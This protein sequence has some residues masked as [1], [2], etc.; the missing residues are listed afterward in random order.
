MLYY[1]FI[2]VLGTM[3]LLGGFYRL[4]NYFSVSV[5]VIKAEPKPKTASTPIASKPIVKLPKVAAQKGISENELKAQ[6]QGKGLSSSQ[7]KYLHQ[8]FLRGDSAQ[9]IA[10]NRLFAPYLG[11][12]GFDS[13]LNDLTINDFFKLLVQKYPQKQ[14]AAMPSGYLTEPKFNSF[15]TQIKKGERRN[16]S[17]QLKNARIVMCPIEKN[18][19]WYLLI[20]EKHNNKS[21]TLRCLD[22]FNSKA[23]HSTFFAQGKK[24][25]RALF[26][27][28]KDLTFN[29]RSIAIPSQKDGYNCGTV[30]SFYGEQF[31]QGKS[32]AQYSTLAKKSFDY[33]PYRL[34][35]GQKLAQ[36]VTKS[37]IF[38]QFDLKKISS[39]KAKVENVDKSLPAKRIV[40]NCC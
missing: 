13:W 34:Q 15:I 3:A 17:T 24:L 23:Q 2:I 20:I 25:I 28:N 12:K 37:P 30:I 14:I 26:K 31:C 32:L 16:F 33:T 21:F 36:D 10:G 22:G 11:K 27:I 18:A 29:E 35:M 39:H 6:I 9:A 19:H 8:R 38:A 1:P 7:I 4:F 5:V 40:I